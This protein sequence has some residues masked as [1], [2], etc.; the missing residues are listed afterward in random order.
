MP[1]FKS[2]LFVRNH[3]LD[4]GHIRLVR[5]GTLAEAYLTIGGLLVQHVA[6][7]RMGALDL[8]GLGE[9]ESL[10]RAGMGCQFGHDIFS[11]LS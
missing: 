7:V 1:F 9:I 8:A 2:S 11:F 10:L 4:G 5:D 3:A 6:L